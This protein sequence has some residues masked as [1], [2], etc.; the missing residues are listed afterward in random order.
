M[1][2]PGP[3]AP[4]L[5]Q[6]YRF[7]TSP[8]SF[9]RAIHRRYGDVVG[10]NT[11]VGKGVAVLEA[12][13][14]R[15]VFAAPPETF[16][17][18][19]VL[20]SIFGPNAVISVSGEPHRKLRKLLNPRFHGAQVKG[21]LSAMQRA[22]RT[23]LEGLGRVA[24]RGDSLALT[25]V[26][27]AMALDVII[28]TVFGAGEV[29]R[30]AARAALREI[31]HAFSPVLAGG[32]TLHK[33]WFP[34]WRRFVRA[35]DAFDRLIGDVVSA[36]RARG[37]RAVEGEDVLGVLLS[38]RY[39]DG[40][41]MSDVEI[42]DQLLTL[43]LAGHETSATAMAWCIYHLLRHPVALERLRSEIDALGDAPAPDALTKLRYLDAVVS[44]TLRIEPIVTD[45]L[46]LCRE[47]FTLGGRW[48][49]PKG[50]LVAVLLVAILRDPRVFDEPG[51]FKPERFLEKKFSASEFLPFGG[52]AR[53]CLGVAF[54]EAELAIAVAEIVS[55]WELEL[56]SEAPERSVRRNLTMG[57]KGG[58]RVRVRGRRRR[59]PERRAS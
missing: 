50:G 12:G 26:T 36:R 17:T 40:A 41:P 19:P 24:G 49:V 53:R 32:G 45:V 37:P 20:E 1:L 33:A 7:V 9:T 48:T 2:P 51:E 56:A 57:P 4:A 13:L 5:W 14:A 42:R 54:A 34:P 28:E 21:F 29:D 25:D 18:V 8:A 59:E 10:L 47:P 22:V 31:I 43:L 39:D 6:T 35:Q 46:R 38:A 23:H 30:D 44:E 58:V 55:R 11:L 3:R 52:G 16:A 15:E 27:Q